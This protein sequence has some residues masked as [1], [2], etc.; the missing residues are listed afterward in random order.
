M[1][2]RLT[3][4][5]RPT[6][7][8]AVVLPPEADAAQGGPVRVVPW[9]D[10]SLRASRPPVAGSRVGD[11]G[12]SEALRAWGS[13]AAGALAALSRSWGTPVT[14]DLRGALGDEGALPSL[15]GGLLE[16][17][18]G[19]GEDDTAAG[20]PRLE[21]AVDEPARWDEALRR[22]L[23]LDA[24]VARAAELTDARSNQLTPQRFADRL[25]Q[26]AAS[27]GMGVRVTEGAA[28]AAEGYR[29]LGA[30][31]QGSTQHPPILVEL[32]IAANADPAPAQPPAG[33]VALAGKGV[34]FDSG[35]LS[36]KP[37][38]GMY[39]MH[40]DCAGAAAVAGALVALAELG[41]PVPVYAALPL[42]ENLPGPE[43]IRPGDVVTA[44]N[45]TT[46]EIADTDFEGR[47]ILADA[48]SRLAEASPRAVVSWATLTYQSEVALGPEIA[49]LFARE[50]ELSR[51]L[52]QAGARAGEALWPMP[53][54]RRYASQLRSGAPGA[55]LRNHPLAATGRAITA[56][57]FL[58]EFVPEHI[59]FAHVDFAGPAVRTGADGPDATGYGVRTIAE[60][61]LGWEHAAEAPAGLG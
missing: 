61:L 8:P 38:A 4:V 27:H 36:I 18:R 41:S 12:G 3:L 34:T 15:L 59:P 50:A 28:V 25:R 19:S 54:A 39:S 49:G 9:P 2:P 32:W 45:G 35:G 60:L 7:F 20:V 47:V 51:R 16:G 30:I 55:Q 23:V 48:L 5:E 13:E 22:E 29:A 40:T 10:G 17:L 31:G 57:L 26:L 24:A 6:V 53:F 33:A 43:A 46:I 42:V 56:A 1:I 11:P 44:R 14:L 52:E 21:V 58:G 37:A